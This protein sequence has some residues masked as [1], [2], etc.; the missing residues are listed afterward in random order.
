METWAMAQET[1]PHMDEDQAERYALGDITGGELARWD[2]HLLICEACR[3]RVQA[4]DEWVHAVQ[5]AAS[6][7]RREPKRANLFTQWL[8][9]AFAAA[10][11]L[12]VVL[13]WVRVPGNDG[14]PVAVALAAN[15]GPGGEAHAPAHEPL[16]LRLDLTGLD[17][18]AS[19]S[20]EIVDAFGRRVWGGA[21][22][23]ES[24]PPLNSGVYFVRLHSPDG[25]L[26]REYALRVE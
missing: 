18:P 19:Y 11:A 14:P 15:R 12:A 25:R 17:A 13:L 22:R 16:A 24:A 2:E 8:L 26:R 7:L 10:A 4:A 20:L 1:E 9:P 21:L 23:G 6:R 3:V 5:A